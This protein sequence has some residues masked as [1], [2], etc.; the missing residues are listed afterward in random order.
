[1]KSGEQRLSLEK[2]LPDGEEA[3]AVAKRL[4][5]AQ[6]DLAFKA[7]VIV[8]MTCLWTGYTLLVRYTRSTTPSVDMY[9]ATT[10]VFLA[11]CAKL[12]LTVVFLFKEH[13]WSCRDTKNLLDRE[14]FGK[15][16]ELAKMS[17]P[18]IAYA[19]QNNLDF[20]ALSYLSAGVYQ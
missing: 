7:Y 2:L 9:N 5:H 17:V 15:P 8:S 11:E 10:V 20:V 4:N 3:V 6:S 16:V 12:L 19:L 13:N 18:S 14:F 1:M